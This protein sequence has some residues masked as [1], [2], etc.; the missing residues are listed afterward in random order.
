[1]A[2]VL[3]GDGN[4]TGLTAGGLPDGSI[5]Q[6][7]LASSVTSLINGPTFRAVRT[8]QFNP[9]GSTWTK[10]PLAIESFD[11]NNNF[12]NATNYRF[13]P[14]VAGYYQFNLH[15]YFTGSPGEAYVS[16]QKNGSQVGYA[17]YIGSGTGW[18]D[19]MYSDIT[20]ANGTT[21]YFEM[22]VYATGSPAIF[23]MFMSGALIRGL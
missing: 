1:M 15:A 11:T 13:T 12:D 7:D 14:T 21:D 8:D 17:V 5:T 10:V 18:W 9:S 4:V 6:A 16:L 23:Q 20:P 19:G 3:N 2:L 22:W